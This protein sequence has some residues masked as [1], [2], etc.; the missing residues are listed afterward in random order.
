LSIAIFSIIFLGVASAIITDQGFTQQAFG[1]IA[2]IA[3][4]FFS[5]WL[6][7]SKRIADTV[8]A[9]HQLEDRLSQSVHS[10]CKVCGKKLSYHRRPKK[11]SQLLLGGLTCENCG[12][13]FDVPFAAFFSQ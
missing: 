8:R 6:S 13:E 4:V 10:K 12:A 9:Q 7:F 2:I 1:N 11:A 3:F 5:M